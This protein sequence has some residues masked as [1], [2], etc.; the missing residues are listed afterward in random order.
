MYY[1]ENEVNTILIV[2]DEPNNLKVL[3]NLL[4]ENNYVVR[5]ALSG[6]AAIETALL[7]PPDLILLDIKMPNMDGY[8]VCQRLKGDSQ[9]Q[10]IPIIF[11]SALNQVE[12]IV[13]AFNVGGVD[14]ITKPFQFEEVIARVNTHLTIIRQQQKLMWQSD[15]LERMIERDRERFE[16]ITNMREKFVRGAAHDLKNPLTI[17]GGYASMMLR[18]DA[19]RQDQNLKQMAQE[20]EGAGADML[21]MIGNMLDVLRFQNS[22][23][24]DKESIDLNLIVDNIVSSYQ[25][26]S[27]AKNTLLEFRTQFSEV[28]IQADAKLIQR[29]VEN[30]VSNAIK[31]SPNES[32][33]MVTTDSKDGK[34]ILQI[35]DD[36]YGIPE[37]DLPL[38]FDPFYRSESTSDKAEGTGLGL[39]VTKEIVE[40]HGGRILVDSREGKGSTFTVI[41]NCE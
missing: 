23:T 28:L 1:Q 31:Y 10:A 33:V 11:I 36:G 16:K 8:E 40:Q 26:L 7:N 5:A 39:S 38:L 6:A 21:E 19:V 24:L 3:H 9:T 25:A 18:M 17:V 30:L 12:D 22:V 29:V 14:Y 41:L 13:S 15:Q 35:E 4:T 20:I 34:A 32:Q 37:Y 27:S 2:D